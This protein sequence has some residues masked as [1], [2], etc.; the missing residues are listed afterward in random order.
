MMEVRG[1]TIQSW[2]RFDPLHI[3]GVRPPGAANGTVVEPM[4]GMEGNAG[5]SLL[6]AAGD[7]PWHP[8][9]PLF[10]FGIL[11]ATT[12]GLIGASTAIRVGP[13]RASASAGK[14]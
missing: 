4:P 3:Y 10:W 11:L 9:S 12:F 6:E 1:A 2:E 7:R 5:P 8:D 13:F 14:S